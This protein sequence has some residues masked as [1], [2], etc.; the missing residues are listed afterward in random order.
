MFCELRAAQ[1]LLDLAGAPHGY[2]LDTRDVADRMLVTVIALGNLR[3]RLSRIS[4]WHARESGPAG[5]VGDLCTECGHPWPCDSR[6]MAD[7]TYA[8][9]ENEEPA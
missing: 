8:E 6:R 9:E 7:G 4:R 5:M 3:E 1:H 2:S